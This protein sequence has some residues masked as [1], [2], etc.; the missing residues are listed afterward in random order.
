M[1]IDHLLCTKHILGTG[2]VT[3]N[4]TSPELKDLQ[5]DKR[6]K[7]NQKKILTRSKTVKE[8]KDPRM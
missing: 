7:K 6:K 8:L 2:D 3:L 5:S 1:F 4:N